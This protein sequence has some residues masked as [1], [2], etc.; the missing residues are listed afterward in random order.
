MSKPLL[1]QWNIG[2]LPIKN[3]FVMCAMGGVPFYNLQGKAM[4]S[5]YDYYVRRAKG[6]AG[7]I[8]TRAVVVLPI[9]L[10]FKLYERP[11]IFMPL[12]SLTEQVHATG[13]KIFCNYLV[14]LDEHY[15]RR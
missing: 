12:H 9:G 7:L 15:I 8:V 13:A 3:R 4:T 10:P 1:E 14:A 5:A 6:G 11:E 2:G